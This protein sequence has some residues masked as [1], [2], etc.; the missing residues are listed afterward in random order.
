MD[1][2]HEQMEKHEMCA[3]PKIFRWEALKR[4]L[5]QGGGP[6][7]SQ[8][9]HNRGKLTV[10][11]RIDYLLDPGS[12]Q[13]M[14]LFVKQRNPMITAD[15]PSDAVVTGYGKI[16]GRPVCVYGHDFTVHGGSL[17]EMGCRKIVELAKKAVAA[18]VPLISLNDSVGARIQ[19]GTNVTFNEL[20]Y[21]NVQGSGWIPQLS[22]VMGPCA[23]AAA[24]SLAL[25]DFVFMVE[26]T[27]HMFLTG[28]G[29]IRQVTGAS[30][31]KENL[32]GAK[33]H[34]TLSGVAHFRCKDDTDCI[35][36]M[37]RLLSYL[38]QNA[39]EKPPVKKSGDDP[40]RLCPELD[41]IIPQEERRPY[42]VKTI[43]RSIVDRDEYIEIMEDWAKNLVTVLARM[44]GRTVGI[45]A[46]QPLVLAG[47]LDLDA[48][49]KGA[50]FVTFC[51]A[52]NIPLIYLADVPGYLPGV[53]QERGGIIRH[54]A[55]LVYANCAATV[56]Q[57]QIVT[58][59]VY[60]GGQAGMCS[61]GIHGDFVYYWPTGKAAIMGAESAAAVLL[62]KELETV[63]PDEREQVLKTRIREYND[64]FGSPY[65]AMEHYNADEIIRPSETRKILCQ[66]LDFLASKE[67]MSNVRKRH[68][69]APV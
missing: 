10:R 34:A 46:N 9:Q 32:G 47:T 19:D 35:D 27:S 15:F 68:G 20:F 8:D 69:I 36:Q 3:D 13:E 43:I 53:E 25:T 41:S 52:F 26:N 54:G 6:E 56:P 60:G 30:I 29:V 66:T 39:D 24:Y 2:Y 50:K 44:D 51:D 55:K 1:I 63:A 21:Y 22:A 14:G 42:D 62:R 61:R 65:G 17:G 7:K 38:P 45:L 12:F 59:K 16:Q 31:D 57:I 5:Q 18:G 64:S 4:I 67:R 58:H 48:S 40:N 37:K 28:P 49:D 23:G 11:E 33:V